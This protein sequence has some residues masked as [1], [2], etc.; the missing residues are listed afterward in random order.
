[1]EEK[2]KTQLVKLIGK[3][4]ITFDIEDRLCYSRDITP[5]SYKWMKIYKLPPYLC[6]CVIRPVDSVQIKN[7]FQ[8]S[9]DFKVPVTIYGG[10]S[11]T[12]GG[13]FPLEGGIT[14]DMSKFN[15]ILYLDKKSELVTVEAGMIGDKLEKVLNLSGYT[16]RH[17]PQSLKSATIGGLIATKSVGQFS[18]KY[19]GIENIL[20]GLD[21]MLP[22]GKIIKTTRTPRTSTGPDL[23][24]LFI[25]S[26]GMFGVIL[27][28]TLKIIKIPEKMVFRSYLCKEFYDGI[29]AIR[30]ILQSG[31]LLPVVRLYNQ[32]ESELKFK[33]LG[34]D[35]VGTL[36]ILCFEGKEGIVNAEIEEVEKI[37]RNNSLEYIGEEIGKMWFEHRFDTKGIMEYNRMD[38]GISDAI[39]ISVNWSEIDN[40]YSKVIE[41]FK[42]RQIKFAAHLS[43][44][45]S[46]GA[47][48]YFIFY[49]KGD[50]EKDAIELF[51]KTWEEVLNITLDNKGSISHH[52]GIGIVKK[53]L[54]KKET[55][56]GYDLITSI[57]NLIDP[58]KILNN[59]KIVN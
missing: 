39:E 48:I 6:D 31:I 26:E 57:K 40:L 41:Y 13:V 23:K 56:Y 4:N 35:K 2:I 46:S 8:F 43:H 37:T 15:K 36:L 50:S 11:G 27:N 18:T 9:N 5:I 34:L 1:M 55:G 19:G 22:N 33:K 51:H 24:N 7:V 53:E 3:D 49:K 16:M 29:N 28:A 12:V 30:E 42:T 54:L 10:G 32:E 17:F 44:I 47:S 25:G 45:Y 38:G 58:N 59:G 14:L 20:I 52:H 21:V